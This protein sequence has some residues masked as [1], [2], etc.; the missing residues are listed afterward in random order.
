M[1]RLRTPSLVCPACGSDKVRRVTAPITVREQIDAAIAPITIPLGAIDR[2]RFGLECDDCGL[3]KMVIRR[4]PLDRLFVHLLIMAGIA[5]AV[6]GLVWFFD[7][8]IH[9]GNLD[10][11]IFGSAAAIVAYL[12][13]FWVIRRVARRGRHR[14]GST[15]GR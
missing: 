13:G 10:L 1:T 15:E 14:V 11:A 7:G 3:R 2:H 6:F 5:G 8:S 4:G 9:R 12:V